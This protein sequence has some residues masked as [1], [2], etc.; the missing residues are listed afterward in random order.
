MS[1]NPGI[2]RLLPID[3]CS[4]SRLF[5]TDWGLGVN[6]DLSGGESGGAFEGDAETA[7]QIA[8]GK[9]LFKTRNDGGHCY[10]LIARTNC[11]AVLKIGAGC[12]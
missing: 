6:G 3:A 7:Y 4:I 12:S 8:L 1:P 10:I 9:I 2:Q 11:A 5:R